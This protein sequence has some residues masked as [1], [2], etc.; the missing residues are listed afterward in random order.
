MQAG[1]KLKLGDKGNLNK[2]N[3]DKQKKQL[4]PVFSFDGL[5]VN[6]HLLLKSNV[7]KLFTLNKGLK[8]LTPTWTPKLVTTLALACVYI[9]LD[10]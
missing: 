9:E 10:I 5:H 4:P 3:T 2:P 6:A 8:T 1:E 7:K